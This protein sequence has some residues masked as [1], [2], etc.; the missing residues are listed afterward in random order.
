MA[1]GD[2]Q[3]DSMSPLDR[4]AKLGERLGFQVE[5]EVRTEVGRLDQVWW[6]SL[7]LRVESLPQ[8]FP[9]VA[10]EVESGWRTRKHIKGDV[11]NLAAFNACLGVVVICGTDPRVQQLRAAAKRFIQA[12]GLGE[13]VCV[14]SDEELIGI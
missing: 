7:L 14:W 11:F 12:L 5:R 9:V 13:R 8:R 3:G 2:A 4:L 1:D 10:F 6:H